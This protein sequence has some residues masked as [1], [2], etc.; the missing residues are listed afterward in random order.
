[1]S[2]EAIL[3]PRIDIPHH[4]MEA[5]SICGKRAHGR[6]LRVIPL[7]A[8]AVAIRVIRAE[9]VTPRI[10]CLRTGTRGKF[11]FSLRKQPIRLSGPL[12]EPGHVALGLVPGHVYDRLLA[13]P[14]AAVADTLRAIAKGDAGVPFV[15]GQRVLGHG[16]RLANCDS[17]LRAFGVG[18]ALLA[19][20]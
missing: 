17:M 6:G 1:M 14:E 12:G 11:V 5:E 10:G 8:A 20:R 3:D 9:V 7:T 2:V 15:E 13:A 4:V 16:K 19:G 18:A